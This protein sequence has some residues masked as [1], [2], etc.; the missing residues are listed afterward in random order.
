MFNGKSFTSPIYDICSAILS[1]LIMII[2]WD[3]ATINS[4]LN[5]LKVEIHHGFRDMNPV[6]NDIVDNKLPPFLHK[7]FGPDTTADDVKDTKKFIQKLMPYI[8]LLASFSM[9]FANN[10]TAINNDNGNN[11]KN[12]EFVNFELLKLKLDTNGDL[13]GYDYIEFKEKNM[14]AINKI[15]D[16]VNIMSDSI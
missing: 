16:I 4:I 9:Y 8:V 11:Y 3:F 1:I 13:D 7:H 12:L 15:I 10:E 6:M 2:G 14:E 5:S